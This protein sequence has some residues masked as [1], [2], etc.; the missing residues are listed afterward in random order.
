MRGQPVQSNISDHA[1]VMRGQPVQSN[2][3]YHPL[4]WEANQYSQTCLII[5]CDE[6]PTCTVKPVLSSTVMRGQP[7]QS[8]LSCIT[9]A[10]RSQPMRSV[11]ILIKVNLSWEATCFINATVPLH[12]SCP[13]KTGSTVIQKGSQQASLVWVIG[14]NEMIKRTSKTNVLGIIYM[15]RQTVW[16][17]AN[18]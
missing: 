1:T 8:N 18:W 7:V 15:I 3:S 17:D 12:Q 10:M 2:L 4:W 5:H 13:D 14:Y 16:D 9:T 11:V 6:R